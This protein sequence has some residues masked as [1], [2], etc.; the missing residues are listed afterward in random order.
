MRKFLKENEKGF[1]LIEMM[2]VLLVITIILLVALPNV[3][4]H[5]SS[6]NE[7]GCEALV[8]MVQGQVQAYYMDKKEYPATLEDLKNDYINEDFE[9]ICPNGVAI[10]I[11]ENGNVK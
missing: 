10:S 6:I 1:T 8:H 4:K 3:T 11:D 9:F 2:I 7:K 5:S